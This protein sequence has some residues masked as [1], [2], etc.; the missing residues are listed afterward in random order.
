MLARL[1]RKLKHEN[2]RADDVVLRDADAKVERVERAA[3]DAERR[4]QLVE[5]RA[6]I[7]S[8]RAAS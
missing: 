4:L 1:M 3:E 5:A 8:R 2:G 7:Y 6:H